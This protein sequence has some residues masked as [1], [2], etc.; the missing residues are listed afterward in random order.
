M[1]RGSREENHGIIFN[2]NTNYI[3]AG[4][5]LDGLGI[6]SKERPK[7]SDWA[8]VCESFAFF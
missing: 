5:Q 8:A 1:K 6:Q 7:S 3:L 2:E 4:H